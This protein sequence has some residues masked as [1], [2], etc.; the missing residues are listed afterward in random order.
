MKLAGGLRLC[1]LFAAVVAGA[2]IMSPCQVVN[3]PDTIDVEQKLVRNIAGWTSRV[4]DTPNRLAGVT[5]FDG[6]PEQQAS[7]VYQS[8]TNSKGKK[9]ATW[10]FGTTSTRLVWIACS[11]SGTNVV[12]SQPLPKATSQCSVTYNMRQ[13]VAGLPLIER[14]TCK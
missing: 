5:F 4:D 10:S 13:S 8:E 9:Y 14:I 2:S 12:L 7:L 11:Y 1:A 6:P 3:C